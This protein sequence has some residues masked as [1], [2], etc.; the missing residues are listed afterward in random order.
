MEQQN[1]YATIQLTQNIEAAANGGPRVV[2]QPLYICPSDA[3]PL[4]WTATKYDAVGNPVGPICEVAT[5]NY[6]GVFGVTEPGVDGEG[7]FFRN[8]KIRIADILDGASQTLMVGERTFALS[9]ST[10]VGAVTGTED[11]PY[12]SSNFVLG[13]TGEANGPA[14]PIDI[15]GFSSRHGVGVNFLFGDGH[16]SFLTGSISQPIYQALSTRAG[17]ETI[18]G[19]Y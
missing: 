13:H 7:V 14:S 15:N 10:W 1:L 18:G 5:A 12:N 17:G 9:P 6:V 8:S 2:S 11:F 16:I 19:D 3:A 4:T